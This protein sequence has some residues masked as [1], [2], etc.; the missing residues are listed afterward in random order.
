MGP[1]LCLFAFHVYTSRAVL[2]A[3]AVVAILIMDQNAL[4]TEI[5]CSNHSFI[6]DNNN[7]WYE[8]AEQVKTEN[9]LYEEIKIR[10]KY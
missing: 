7:R 1:E 4:C 10:V 8:K 2:L 5:W 3:V 9:T 6:S